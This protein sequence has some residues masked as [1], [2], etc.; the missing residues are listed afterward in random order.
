MRRFAGAISE[1]HARLAGQVR[2]RMFG[3][4]L[5]RPR[6]CYGCRMKVAPDAAIGEDV[7]IRDDVP[8]AFD[9]VGSFRV[10]NGGWMAYAD[11]DYPDWLLAR[12]AEGE[13]GRLVVVEL[14]LAG[15]RID[16][17]FLRRVPVPRLEMVANHTPGVA[18]MIRA[19]LSAAPRP[20][21]EPNAG[22][23]RDSFRPSWKHGEGTSEI[24]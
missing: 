8:I 12:F 15:A 20:G 13:E 10:G 14:H 19:V 23:L 9:T 4:L 21:I 6:A 22:K 1:P 7:E 5:R 11:A 16:S 3:D 2:D 24:P 17:G 18:D